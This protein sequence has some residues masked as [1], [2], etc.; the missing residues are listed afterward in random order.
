MAAP[1]VFAKAY[2]KIEGGAKLDC[3]FNPTQYSISKTS[4]WST[5]TTPGQPLPVPQYTG[6]EPRTLSV[7]LLFDDS[8][9]PSGDVR[10]VTE[11]LF[12]LL[13]LDPSLSSAANKNSGRPPM[14]EF[15]WGAATTFTAMVTALNVQYTLFRSNGTPVRAT[16]KLDLLQAQEIPG[17]G[18]AARW[19][20]RQNPTTTGLAGIRSWRVRDGDSLHSIAF[21]EYGDP[22]RWRVIAEA[23]DID[24]PV[25]LRRG[26]TLVVPRLEE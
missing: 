4:T 8:E 7:E 20:A 2:L 6:G 26:A 13:E 11:R 15:G 21:A 25:R 22:T 1:D 10:G 3:W 24:D 19:K 17:G 23:N 18:S 14:V 9:A 12:G 5:R 16:A